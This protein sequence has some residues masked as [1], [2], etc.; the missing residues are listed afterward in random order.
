VGDPNCPVAASL[1]ENGETG[2]IRGASGGD[3]HGNLVELSY[4]SR[5]A[6]VRAGQLVVTSGQGGVFPPGIPVGT[7]VDART[8]GDGIFIEARVRLAVSMGAVDH[9]WVKLP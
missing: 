6:A 2:I 1:L 7:L 9:V 3:L 8:V 4:L 5:H